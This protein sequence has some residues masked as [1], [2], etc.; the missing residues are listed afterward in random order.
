MAN[1]KWQMR[2]GKSAFCLLP[3]AFCFLLSAFCFLLSAFC[4]LLSAFCFLLSAFCFL[5]SAS[6]RLGFGQS[7][8]NLNQRSQS[9]GLPILKS[10]RTLHYLDQPSANDYTEFV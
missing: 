1:E 2:N 7:S 3:S 8:G 5:P 6:H 4:L 9:A 10:Y